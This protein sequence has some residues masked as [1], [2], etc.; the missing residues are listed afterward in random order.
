[1]GERKN[2]IIEIAKRAYV[3]PVCGE[4][5]LRGYTYMAGPQAVTIDRYLLPYAAEWARVFYNGEPLPYRSLFRF[6]IFFCPHDYLILDSPVVFKAGLTQVDEDQILFHKGNLDWVAVAGKGMTFEKVFELLLARY[7]DAFAN[8]DWYSLLT[9]DVG[10]KAMDVFGK[11]PALF[12][13]LVYTAILDG[14]S[15]PSSRSRALL[16]RLVDGGLAG[17]IGNKPFASKTLCSFLLDYKMLH[18]A[19]KIARDNDVSISLDF[20]DLTM[21][22]GEF[23][24]RL[25]KSGLYERRD[26]GRLMVV[27][28]KRAKLARTAF[29]I[30]KLKMLALMCAELLISSGDYDYS[31]PEVMVRLVYHNNEA[32]KY[33]DL[34][35]RKELKIEGKLLVE[36]ERIRNEMVMNLEHNDVYFFHGHNS[37]ATQK[38]LRIG[39]RIRQMA[40][41]HLNIQFD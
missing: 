16:E 19:L 11:N 39:E 12:N 36:P 38:A 4:R 7:R 26:I 20:D 2:H 6:T 22:L 35:L 34:L 30:W 10:E 21:M 23:V 27:A 33:L 15:D 37:R 3:C 40:A 8:I 18:Y 28:L 5:S 14:S 9:E 1:M 31:D 13:S 25:M 17:L 29:E 41:K 32:I 24:G